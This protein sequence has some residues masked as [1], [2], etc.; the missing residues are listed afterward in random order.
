MD[1]D[2]ADDLDGGRVFYGCIVLLWVLTALP[3][4]LLRIGM[5][6]GLLAALQFVVSEALNGSLV[7]IY[8]LLLSVLMPLVLPF[9][10]AHE[11]RHR[12]PPAEKRDLPS[13]FE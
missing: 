1:P 6:G 12:K 13:I 4:W 3:L 5:I 2:G 11:R 7:E 9:W 8:L 10:V